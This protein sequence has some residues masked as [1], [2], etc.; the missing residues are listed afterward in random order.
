VFTY[1]VG[2]EWRAAPRYVS[3]SVFV[4]PLAGAGL[5]LRS[6]DARGVRDDARHGAAAFVAVGAES[7][8]RRV[9]LRLELRD[10]VAN[11]ALAQERGRARNDMAVLFGVRLERR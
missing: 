3:K 5:G 9:R 2:A 1:D 7:G 10:Y 8:V 4:R 11:T 6:Y